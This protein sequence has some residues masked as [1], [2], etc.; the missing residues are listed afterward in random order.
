MKQLNEYN[1]ILFRKKRIKKIFDEAKN[2]KDGFRT[3]DEEF[4]LCAKNAKD[5]FEEEN[6]VKFNEL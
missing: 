1:N 2:I 6:N 4:D 3:L 5:E